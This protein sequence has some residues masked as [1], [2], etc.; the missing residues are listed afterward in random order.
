MFASLIWEIEEYP[1]RGVLEETLDVPVIVLDNAHAAG[2]G[3][4]WLMGRENREHLMYFYM[5]V[6][7]GGAIITGRDLYEGRN[8]TAGEIGPTIIDP[9]GPDFGCHRG[10]LE[11][12]L[13]YDN[14]RAVAG[15][16]RDEYPGSIL[17]RDLS[18]PVIIQ[19]IAAAA[20]DRLALLILRYAAKYVS[21]QT[22]NMLNLLNPD[23]MILGGPFGLWG[24]RFAEM[25][26]AVAETTALPISFRS[27]SVLPGSPSSESIPLG[28]AAMIIRRAPALLSPTA[29]EL[30]LNS[31]PAL[32]IAD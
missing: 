20:E 17:S 3:E 10:C 32:R 31:I 2:L 5:G 24:E 30:L 12:F 21:I 18:D 15:E 19:H 11:G 25:V 14:L 7:T 28:A 16:L 22:A 23:E 29:S 13:R 27:A 9:D 26:S 4:L 8:H 6:G 1:L